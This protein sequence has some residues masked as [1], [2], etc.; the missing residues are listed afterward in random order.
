MAFSRRAAQAA[1]WQPPRLEA[2][3][4]PRTLL[5]DQRPPPGRPGAV[6][7]AAPEVSRQA[8]HRCELCGGVGGSNRGHTIE[9]HEVWD[10]DDRTWVQRLVRLTALCPAC[11]EVKD[12]CL[13]VCRHPAAY[14]L[15]RY[16]RGVRE[17]FRLGAG[18]GIFCVG[19]CWALM[20][21]GFAAGVANLWWM[22]AL[23]AVMVFEK[24]GPGGQRGARPIG[25]GLLLPGILALADPSWMASM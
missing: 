6:G 17:A 7:P 3:L 23:T 20:L 8:G 13:T 25:V 19:C 12:R 1:A 18:H 24:I 11:H 21:A 15:P 22:A 10:Y 14:P 4:V 5:V 9:C 2:E 16:R